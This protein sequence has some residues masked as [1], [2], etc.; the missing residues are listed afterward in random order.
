MSMPAEVDGYTTDQPRR[1]RMPR[2]NLGALVATLLLVIYGLYFAFAGK[3]DSPELMAETS[4]IPTDS[5][6]YVQKADELSAVG[7]TP[8]ELITGALNWLSVSLVFGYFQNLGGFGPLAFVLINGVCLYVWLSGAGVLF[9]L[10]EPSRSVAA[11]MSLAASPFLFGWMLAPNKELPTAA[12]LIVILRQAQRGH[13]GRVL[14]ISILAALF[15]LQVLLAAL[16]YTLGLKLRYR[17]SLTLFGLSLLIP[18]L[19]PL[20]DGLSITTFLESQENEINSGAFFAA[21]DQINSWP[22]GYVVVAPVRI[23]ASIFAGLIPLRVFSYTQ[24]ADLLASLT[25]F[26]LGSLAV[27][28]LI[29]AMSDGAQ[30]LDPKQFDA[31][32]RDLQPYIA[33]WKQSRVTEVAAAL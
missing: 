30:S 22:L 23:A 3:L 15:K 24:P 20:V 28:C 17:R 29:K 9:R 31:M 27:L 5:L 26:A 6:N 10:P 7:L 32:M 18:I 1:P 16:I 12:L 11:L 2:P 21:L 14:A 13:T 19:M 4:L 33:L 8:V 25:S